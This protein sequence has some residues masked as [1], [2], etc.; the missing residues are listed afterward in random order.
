MALDAVTIVSVIHQI[1]S[2]IGGYVH[3]RLI[4]KEGNYIFVDLEEHKHCCLA[5][6]G[7]NVC[8]LVG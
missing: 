8:G 3:N 7:T 1:R 6:F 4:G 2:R 5:V